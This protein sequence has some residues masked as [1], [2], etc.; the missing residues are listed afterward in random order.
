MMEEEGLGESSGGQITG[1]APGGAVSATHPPAA[2]PQSQPEE[3]GPAAPEE[4]FD[5]V[6]WQHDLD[7]LLDEL[8]D[9]DLA[10]EARALVSTKLREALKQGDAPLLDLLTSDEILNTT[11]QEP[12]W[13]I[14]DLL[15][16]GLGILA[17]KP[18]AGKSWLGLQGVHAVSAGGKFLTRNIKKGRTLYLAL[19]D[20]PRRLKDRMQKQR[21]SRGLPADFMPVGK[22]LDQV[23]TLEDGGAE[24][25]ARQIGAKEYRLVV[26]DTLSRAIQRDQSDVSEMT[27]ALAPLQEMAH[28]CNC[29]VLLIDH[30]R[31]SSPF[32]QDVISDILGSTAKGAVADTA[33]G[34]YRERGKAGAKLS[35]VGRDVLE[36]NLALTWDSTLCCWHS[37]GDADELEM[38]ERRREIIDALAGLGK[39]Q[40]DDIATAVGRDRGNTFK[41]LQDLAGAGKVRRK[42]EG[43]KVF[44]VL[45]GNTE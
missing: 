36:Q 17:G 43:R 28:R 37:E 1:A 21:W 45:A 3:C 40:V 44:Y 6:S 18:K 25:L 31:K 13:A 10:A 38:T 4:R 41:R 20:P 26:I 42:R 29:A 5:G 12:S 27:Q 32:N 24:R 15:P 22:F 19:E 2:P 33:W 8:P 7:A 30:H 11:W 23:G 34:L 35:V 16:S 14:E 9:P 39:A